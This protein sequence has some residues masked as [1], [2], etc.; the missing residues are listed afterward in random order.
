MGTKTE[1]EAQIERFRRRD[2]AV[3]LR[4]ER[5]DA[6]MISVEVCAGC[7]RRGCVKCPT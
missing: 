2:A 5:E 4:K 7:G 1:K 3:R 6:R